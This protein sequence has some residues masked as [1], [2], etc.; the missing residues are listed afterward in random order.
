MHGTYSTIICQHNETGA[1]SRLTRCA[2]PCS[3]REMG[4]CTVTSKTL[5]VSA[6]IIPSY[7]PVLFHHLLCADATSGC[8]HPSDVSI[9][10][11]WGRSRS[12]AARV[13]VLV[14]LLVGKNDLLFNTR[15]FRARISRRIS[16]SC[17]ESPVPAVP[18]II[19]D[20]ALEDNIPRE[21]V[22][23]VM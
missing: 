23:V 21:Y 4:G 22:C 3:S 20:G 17:T 18:R 14:P 1:D 13:P 19:D 9:G 7:L 12:P 16:S 11:L 5:A 10:S 6:V 2:S 15:P 8:G